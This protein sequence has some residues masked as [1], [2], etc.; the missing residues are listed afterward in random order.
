MR[1]L[2]EILTGRPSRRAAALAA[3]MVLALGGLGC[4]T[5]RNTPLN[6]DGSAA[7][8]GAGSGGHGGAGGHAGVY[9]M[10]QKNYSGASERVSA[11][12]GADA[13]RRQHQEQS[14]DGQAGAAEQRAGAA[15]ERHSWGNCS[16]PHR[17]SGD[18]EV[19]S[20][21]S[22]L[23]LVNLNGNSSNSG[24]ELRPAE[25]TTVKH[26]RQAL[27]NQI[28]GALGTQQP[29]APAPAQ[30]QQIDMLFDGS[31]T[32][33]A[34]ACASASPDRCR[35]EAGR[36]S[37][38]LLLLRRGREAAGST[39]ASAQLAQQ[40]SLG[41]SAA[42]NAACPKLLRRWQDRDSTQQRRERDSAPPGFTV[43]CT[44]GTGS[45]CSLQL[46]SSFVHLDLT[47]PQRCG[48]AG[49][50]GRS[51]ERRLLRHLS[52]RSLRC[53]RCRAALWR[54]VR[55]SLTAITIVL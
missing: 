43:R 14:G 12:A 3:A 30:A 45:R 54:R 47:H 50:G 24:R 26:R 42:A 34:P 17:P 10:K 40:A 27:Q 18:P 11:G 38:Q 6:F 32:G 53:T 31:P 21:T 2:V 20:N 15:E 51:E 23:D 9:L 52:I 33:T 41:Q 7:G 1:A 29:A 46:R 35:E 44:A 13:E 55:R 48:S 4:T 39:P 25:E 8:A 5:A 49:G 16:A 36:R 37:F 22:P 19:A 28:D